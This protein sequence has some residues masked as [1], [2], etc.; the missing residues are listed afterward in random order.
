MNVPDVNADEIREVGEPTL[1]ILGFSQEMKAE[2]F[3]GEGGQP[4][5]ND[6]GKVHEHEDDDWNAS[7]SDEILYYGC[8]SRMI[9]HVLLAGKLKHEGRQVRRKAHH[10]R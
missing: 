7:P 5:G 10:A 9:V 2:A 1:D 6:D 4:S 3:H 8:A